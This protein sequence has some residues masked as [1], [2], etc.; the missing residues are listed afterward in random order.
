[1]KSS[2]IAALIIAAWSAPVMAQSG[3]SYITF[4][5]GEIVLFALPG[6]EVY[7]HK[8]LYGHAAWKS[9]TSEIVCWNY[10]NVIRIH[11]T[12][13]DRTLI[14]DPS[15]VRTRGVNVAPSPSYSDRSGVRFPDRTD[16]AA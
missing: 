13:E 7:G 12:E 4:D 8:G 3:D 1:M 9:G 5:E 15:D 2:A 6:C 14:F 10:D 16:R 11:T